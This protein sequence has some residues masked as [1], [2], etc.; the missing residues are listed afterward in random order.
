MANL[1]PLPA[2]KTSLKIEAFSLGLVGTNPSLE[3]P[4][5]KLISF[6]HDSMRIGRSINH[7]SFLLVG[8]S[9]VGKSS[10]INHLLGTKNGIKFAKTSRVKSETKATEEFVLCGDEPRYEVKDLP[11]GLVDTPGF[12][13]T[14]GS[15]QDAC[16][17]LSIKKCFETHEKLSGC[18]PNLIFLLVRATDSRLEGNNSSLAKALRLITQFKLVDTKNP[19]VVAVLTSACSFPFGKVEKWSQKIAEKKDI[20]SWI[21]FDA[22]KVTAPVVALENLYGEDD[23]NLEISGD[24]T[25]LPNTVLQPKNLYEACAAVLTKNSDHLALITLNSV[26]AAPKKTLLDLDTKLMEKMWIIVSWALKK[27]TVCIHWKVKLEK[28]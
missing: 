1:K 20:V 11:L 7:V 26:F 10:T 17:L 16:N 3:E 9:G 2:N 6:I 5:A 4:R 28:V 18:Y 27:M 15:R 13:D 12:G 8:M 19:N 21:I 22:L 25:R 24:Y 14:D 23:H